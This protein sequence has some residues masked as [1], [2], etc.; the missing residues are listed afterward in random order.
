MTRVSQIELARLRAE[1]AAKHRRSLIAE[2]AG[3]A[4]SDDSAHDW[5][6]LLLVLTAIVLAALIG[7]GVWQRVQDNAWR[8]RDVA[9]TNELVA[10]CDANGNTPHIDRDARGRILGFRCGPAR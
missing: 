3:R 7:Y 6:R 5:L 10:E 4:W 1:A 9:Y 8:L 2:E